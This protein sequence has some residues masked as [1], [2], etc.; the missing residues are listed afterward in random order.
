MIKETTMFQTTETPS[1]SAQAATETNSE[2]HN[3]Q[4]QT[5]LQKKI[6]TE[7]K[8]KLESKNKDHTNKDYFPL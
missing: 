6:D 8:K 3:Q 4:K 1:S 7:I 2:S 5:G